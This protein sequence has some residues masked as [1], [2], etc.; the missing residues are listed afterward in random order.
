MNTTELIS[1]LKIH[2]SF[3]TSNDLFSAADFLVLFNHQL[4]VDITPLMMK[5]NE[6]FFLRNSDF[7]IT[8]G[9][10]YRIPQRAVGSQLRDLQV[11]DGSGNRNSLIRLYEEDRPNNPSGYYVFRNSIELS[12]DFNTGTLRMVYFGRPS[13]LVATSACAQI[14]SIDTATNTVVVSSVP[15]T[16]TNG[17][18]VDLVQN[19]NPYDLIAIDQSVVGIAGTTLNFSS[20]P[21]GLAIGDWICL[22]GESPIPQVPDELHPLLVQSVLC[23]T[24]SAKKD[25]AYK[26]ELETL[27]RIKAD[28]INMLNPRVANNSAKIRT[29]LL[30]NYFNSHR[31]Y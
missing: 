16:F 6:E 25:K 29:G 26:E 10:S 17:T 14:L 19:N 30:L 3:P 24:L 13:T 21:D 8:Q 11:L 22:A 20:L 23:K 31:Y 18:L 1:A 9:S 12:N 28:A 4:K 15:T 27:E 7:T 5:L 2:G